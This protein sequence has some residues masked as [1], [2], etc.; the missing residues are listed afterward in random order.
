[1]HLSRLSDDRYATTLRRMMEPFDSQKKNPE[2]NLSLRIKG[3]PVDGLTPYYADFRKLVSYY[4]KKFGFASM[5][6][7]NA[8]KPDGH[9]D[10]Y[11]AMG[12]NNLPSTFIRCSAKAIPDGVKLVNGRIMDN[13]EDRRRST[14]SHFFLLPKYKAIVEVGY[15]RAVMFDWKRIEQRITAIMEE[16][17]LK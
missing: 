1:M 8:S 12:K 7:L 10:W 6:T 5:E 11:V 3:D 15:L 17:E 13:P 16:A 4:E 2:Y 14:C 9:E